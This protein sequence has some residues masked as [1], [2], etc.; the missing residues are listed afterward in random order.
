MI[1][2]IL[3]WVSIFTGG[4]LIIL[5][6]LSLL[7]GLDLD[8]DIETAST[9]VETDAGGIGLLKGFLTFVST[10]A[11]VIRILVSEQKNIWVAIAIGV[12]VGIFCFL[13]LNYIFKLLL[14]NESNVNWH[15]E[16][17]LF[18]EGKVYL[19]VPASNESSGIVHVEINNAVREI[20]ARSQDKIEIKTGETIRVTDIQGEYV[21]VKKE[22]L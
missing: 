6:L 9:D 7:G 8:I 12:I 10:S 2:N 13:L 11:W 17:A 14:K 15:I 20:K 21:I 5:M 4:L 22:T 18:Q 1:I 3:F 19:K 16:D